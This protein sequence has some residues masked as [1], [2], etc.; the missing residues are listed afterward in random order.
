[1]SNRFK[2]KHTRNKNGPEVSVRVHEFASPEE[3]QQ[4]LRDLAISSE[5][6]M[7]YRGLF[8]YY[9]KDFIT[10]KKE[11]PSEKNRNEF[12]RIIS[13]YMTHYLEDDCP[14]SWKQCPSSFWEVLIFSFYPD[15]IKLSPNEQEVENF[16]YQLKK[17][18]RWLDKR[19]GTTWFPSVEEFATEAYSELKICER[20]INWIFLKDFP[21]IHHDD[22]NLE[23]DINRLKQKFNQ[24]TNQ[25]DSSFKVT[26]IIGERVVLS[27]VRTNCTY[28]IK[29]LPY[30]FI[31]PG[32]KLSGVICNKNGDQTWYW[33]HTNGIYPSKGERLKYPVSIKHEG[34]KTSDGVNFFKK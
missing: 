33:Y 21:R 25:V 15:H 30:E 1:M 13:N 24:Y 20:F 3:R 11:K 18:A 28:Y 4:L 19:N 29:G 22:W 10:Y 8:E 31:S 34:L 6:E 26:S 27:E 32:M 7:R 17:F 16:L 5:F 14:P 23:Q 12:L 9:G 2:K